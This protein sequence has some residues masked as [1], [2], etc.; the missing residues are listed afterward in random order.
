MAIF[1]FWDEIFNCSGKVSCSRDS[2]IMPV[3]GH[4]SSSPHSFVSLADTSSMPVSE[5][6]FRKNESVVSAAT[7][8]LDSL[9]DSIGRGEKV[10]GVCYGPVQGF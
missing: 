10:L 5:N 4:Y 3:S 8:L 6:G 7:E 9:I 2:L 1:V